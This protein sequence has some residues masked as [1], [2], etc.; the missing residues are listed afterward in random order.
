MR[1]DIT[2]RRKAGGEM[3]AI[4]FLAD[5]NLQTRRFFRAIKKMTEPDQLADKMMLLK[6]VCDDLMIHMRIEELIF[7]PALRA[8]LHNDA[9]VEE[10]LVQHDVIRALLQDLQ[11]APAAHPTFDAT[12]EALSESIDLHATAKENVLF[13]TAL[14]CSLDTEA[15]GRMLAAASYQLRLEC[16]RT[17]ETI[18]ID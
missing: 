16:R 7:Y 15:L 11:S 3:D 5:D 17:A 12:L 10:A 18:N 6:Q 4:E 13:P 1:S 14:D 2:S 8:Q 9:L